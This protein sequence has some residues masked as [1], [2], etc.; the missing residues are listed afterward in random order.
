MCGK[1]N[2]TCFCRRAWTFKLCLGK[3]PFW[4]A[5]KSCQQNANQA[6]MWISGILGT[7]NVQALC[8]IPFCHNT[9]KFFTYPQYFRTIAQVHVNFCKLQVVQL[10]LGSSICLISLHWHFVKDTHAIV[11][12]ESG[13]SGFYS[14]L[15]IAQMCPPPHYSLSYAPWFNTDGI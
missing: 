12:W 10:C 2:F 11:S 9:V 3:E 5:F 13:L 15:I 7:V 8:N 14:C 1:S 4:K 6:K